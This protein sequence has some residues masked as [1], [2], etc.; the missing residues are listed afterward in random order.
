MSNSAAKVRVYNVDGTEVFE[1]PSTGFPLTTT[2]TPYLAITGDPDT[3]IKSTHCL[4]DATYAG[5]I[6]LE[7]SNMPR[8]VNGNVKPGDVADSSRTVGHWVQ[9][10]PSTAYVAVVGSGHSASAATVTAVTGNAGACMYHVGNLGAERLRL[11]LTCTTNGSVRIR[12]HG[13]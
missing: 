13:K 3:K 4:W 6:T 5:V 7:S 8:T 10:N 12:V 11:N 9:E 1:D 2:K